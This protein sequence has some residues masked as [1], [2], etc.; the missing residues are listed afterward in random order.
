[1]KKTLIL[2]ILL[3]STSSI[4]SVDREKTNVPELTVNTTVLQIDLDKQKQEL[5]ESIQISHD[6][7]I[8]T[9]KETIK[10]DKSNFKI[11]EFN[12]GI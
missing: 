10:I 11:I 6:E 4:A 5:R 12:Q 3:T 8:K 2:A 7:M 1:M 9:M